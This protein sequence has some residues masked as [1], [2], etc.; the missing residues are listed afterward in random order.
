MLKTME[1]RERQ[2]EQEKKD[3]YARENADVQRQADQERAEEKA[4]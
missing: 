1:D 2:A 4:K 3:K